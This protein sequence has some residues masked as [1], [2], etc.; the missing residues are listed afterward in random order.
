MNAAAAKV[1]ENAN[2]LNTQVEAELQSQTRKAR[3]KR[4]ADEIRTELLEL[5]EELR[6]VGGEI[7]LHLPDREELQQ[8]GEGDSERS[9]R[10]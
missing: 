6:K 2:A 9:E 3:P 5:V 10:S 7:E 4:S 1:Q 8:L